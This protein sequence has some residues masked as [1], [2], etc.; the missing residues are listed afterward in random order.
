MRTPKYVKIRDNL[1]DAIRRGRYA[2]GD[3]LPTREVLQKRFRTTRATVDKALGELARMG[4]TRGRRRGGTIVLA[5]PQR[6]RV[7]VISQLAEDRKPR[8]RAE[9]NDLPALFSSLALHGHGVNWDFLDTSATMENPDMLHDFDAVVWIQPEVGFLERLRGIDKKLLITNRYLDDWNFVSTDHRKA[10]AGLT[11]K[12]LRKAGQQAAV[13]FLE[14]NPDRFVYAERR[15]G[16]LDACK[17]MRRFYRMLPITDNNPDTLLHALGRAAPDPG[18]MNLIICPTCVF[19]GPLLR[20]A[21]RLG[22]ELGRNLLYGDVDNYRSP[23]S[24]GF[25]VPTV[26]QDYQAMGMAV[27][28]ALQSGL[29]EPIKKFVPHRLAG[30]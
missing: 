17:R 10:M 18:G 13:Y 29:Q 9:P 22:L 2:P 3:C 27:V 25:Q 6:R 1:L 23:D 21:G 15:E 14:F 19:C 4:I 8:M 5:V 12:L 30:I 20:A 11:G 26:L 24:L 16:F 28:E 7:A